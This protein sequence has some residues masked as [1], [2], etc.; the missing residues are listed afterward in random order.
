M[1]L[2]VASWLR[3]MGVLFMLNSSCFGSPLSFCHHDRRLCVVGAGINSGYVGWPPIGARLLIWLAAPKSVRGMLYYTSN[4]RRSAKLGRRTNRTI[5]TDVGSTLYTPEKRGAGA[6]RRRLPALSGA[7]G[8]VPI[9]SH[10]LQ[11]P[12]PYCFDSWC[13]CCWRML[14]GGAACRDRCRASGFSTLP[15]ASRIR[16]SSYSCP[17]D[18]VGLAAE[19]VPAGNQWQNDPERLEAV[20][21][22]APGGCWTQ[23]TGG[24]DRV[25]ESGR[26]R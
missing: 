23:L 7:R 20:R 21:W 8:A 2:H 6:G 13:C 1:L 10:R 22:P 9:C 3:R 16:S 12:E 24:V 15:A 17:S 19:L 26:E 4:A 25:A 14:S 11:L 5:I 18:R